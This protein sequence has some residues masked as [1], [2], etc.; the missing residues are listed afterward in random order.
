MEPSNKLS[1][2]KTVNSKE[3]RAHKTIV[4][5]EMDLLYNIIHASE[6]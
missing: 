6:W 3:E 1:I 2:S 5:R 4:S